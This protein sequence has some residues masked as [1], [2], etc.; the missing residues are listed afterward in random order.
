MRKKS[1]NKNRKQFPVNF[2]YE[3]ENFKGQIETDYYDLSNYEIVENY[4]QC[5]IRIP[6]G[7]FVYDKFR[8]CYYTY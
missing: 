4:K 5:K 1:V 3:F 6:L 8:D 2:D 7:T